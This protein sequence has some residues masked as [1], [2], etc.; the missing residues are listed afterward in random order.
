MAILQKSLYA[1]I[2]RLTSFTKAMST[3]VNLLPLFSEIFGGGGGGKTAA[4]SLKLFVIQSL[5]FHIIFVWFQNLSKILNQFLNY[6][7][8]KIVSTPKKFTPPPPP[9]NSKVKTSTSTITLHKDAYSSGQIESKLWF[10]RELEKQLYKSEPQTI[11]LLGGWLGLLSFLLLSRERLKIK[12][13]C[14]FDQD[15]LCERTANLI[16]ENWIWKQQI[17]KAKTVDC[18]LIDYK[19]PSCVDS[20]EPSLIINTSVEHFHSKKWYFNIPSGKLVVLQSC[21]LKHKDHIFCVH[22]E[23]EFKKQFPLTNLYYSGTL[24]FNYPTTSFSRYMLIGRK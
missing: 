8:K 11:W 16:N 18:N 22:S 10:C 12:S 3:S 5:S 23:E 15:P 4:R 6:K 21:N 1:V 9:E 13:I 7:I 20:E 17:F 24:D 19:N 2:N 14:S